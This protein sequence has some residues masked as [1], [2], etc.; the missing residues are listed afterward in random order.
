MSGAYD[1]AGRSGEHPAVHRRDAPGGSE[2]SGRP[3]SGAS[4]SGDARRPSSDA[5]AGA[6]GGELEVD[7]VRVL[8]REDDEAE[9]GQVGDLAVLDA[10]RLQPLGRRVQ[11]VDR[12][13]PQAQVVEADPVGIESVADRCDGTQPEGLTAERERAAPVGALWIVGSSIWSLKSLPGGM[14]NSCS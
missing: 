2:S 4:T 7:V 1:P 13:D 12:A 6:G 14:P 10:G 9:R 3:R 5:A 8:Q 11:L